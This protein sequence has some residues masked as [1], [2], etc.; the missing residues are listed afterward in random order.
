MEYVS[1]YLM[2]IIE[3]GGLLAPL[4]FI[5]IHLLRP[6]FFLPVVFICISGGLLF[7]TVAGTLYSIIGITLSSLIFYR[8]AQWMPKTVDKLVR[9]KQKMVGSHS[10]LTTSQVALLRLIPF[11]HFHLLSLC[12]LEVATDFRGYLKA[13]FV[14]NIPIAVVYTSVG[15]TMSTFSPL[16][17]VCLLISLLPCIYLLRRKEITMKWE[18]FFQTKTS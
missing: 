5:G 4:L 17:T 13:S 16:I 8:M 12:I 6:L 1:T 10:K 14:S 3:T 11:I 18:D 15:K 9:M 2:A 7:G